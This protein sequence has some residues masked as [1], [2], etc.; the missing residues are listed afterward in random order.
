MS[1][2]EQFSEE[3]IASLRALA[4]AIIPASEEHGLPGADDRLIFSDLKA[5]AGRQHQA[6][7]AALA[8]LDE[9]A[10]AGGGD[11]FAALDAPARE[12]VTEAFR[13]AHRP[14]ADLLAMLTVQ[15]YYRDDRVMRALDMETRPPFPDGFEVPEGDWTLLDPVRNRPE[16]YRKT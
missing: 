6:V 14:Q 15:C 3:E 10:H 16:F 5:S 1:E 13:Q 4:A 8:A 7:G 12:G 9:L 2:Q 11:S